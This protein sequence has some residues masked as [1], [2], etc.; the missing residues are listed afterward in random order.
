MSSGGKQPPQ[1]KNEAFAKLERPDTWGRPPHAH[2]NLRIPQPVLA[3]I[4][5]G[6]Q[7]LEVHLFKS[8]STRYTI[9]KVGYG[10]NVEPM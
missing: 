10:T 7:T 6:R 8:E 2:W 3:P 1:S 9:S 4:R 5:A